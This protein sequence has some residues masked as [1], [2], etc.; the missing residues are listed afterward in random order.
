MAMAMAMPRRLGGMT[1]CEH[2]ESERRGKRKEAKEDLAYHGIGLSFG[3]SQRPWFG[4]SLR[5]KEGTPRFLQNRPG[6][7][8]SPIFGTGKNPDPAGFTPE[9]TVPG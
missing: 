5:L 6:V 3:E 4:L 9:S 1:S 2:G 8:P 7:T